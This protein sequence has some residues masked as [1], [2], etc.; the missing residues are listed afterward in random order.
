VEVPT[1][2]GKFLAQQLLRGSQSG[3]EVRIRGKGMPHVRGGRAGDLV[4]HLRVIIPRNL[5]KRQ[6]DLLRELG[7][8]DGVHVQPERKSFLERVREFFS[9]APNG[10]REQTEAPAKGKAGE[11]KE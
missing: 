10:T 4:V 7:E 3:D 5:T 6:E 8:L 2:E 1:L 9:S 11:R